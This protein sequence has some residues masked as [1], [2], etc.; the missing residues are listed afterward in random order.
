MVQPAAPSSFVAKLHDPSPAMRF[1]LASS[2][3]IVAITIVPSLALA[4]SGDLKAGRQK[5]QMCQGCHGLDGLSKQPNAPH[6]A[7][8][9]E[10]YLV[11]AMTEYRDKVRKHEQMSIAAQDLTDKDIA[12]LAAYYTAIQITTERPK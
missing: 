11:K 1:C 6:L 12:D 9:P 10:V 2:A 4:Q 8:Q 5:A 7:G 3:M